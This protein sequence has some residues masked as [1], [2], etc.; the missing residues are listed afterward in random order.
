VDIKINISFDPRSP[1]TSE[2]TFRAR[3]DLESITL[4]LARKHLGVLDIH[5]GI[6]SVLGQGIVGYSTRS[7]YMR[8]RTF[9]HSSES[10]EEEAKIGS[11]DAIDRVIRQ[12]VNEQPFS[13]LR[14]LAKGH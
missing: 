4:Y 1:S 6:N 3:M 14:Q 11:C 2:R 8:K 10:A 5:T 7:R 12:S 13:S 9:P